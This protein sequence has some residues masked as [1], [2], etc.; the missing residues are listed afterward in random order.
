VKNRT[1]AIIGAVTIAGIA[2]GIVL[3]T[4][5]LKM[6][7]PHAPHVVDVTAEN[8][9]A[10]AVEMERTVS[11]PIE[12]ALS[13]PFMGRVSSVSSQGRTLVRVTLDD[14]AD[15]MAARMEI[16]KR[17]GDVQLPPS[18]FTNIGADSDDALHFAMD[19]APGTDLV[20]LRTAADWIVERALKQLPGVS[21]V[22]TCGGFVKR[23]H[24]DL[25]LF[26]MR[27]YGLSFGDVTSALARPPS[28]ALFAG[29]AGIDEIAKTVI[30]ERHEAPVQVKDVAT[31]AMGHAPRDCVA[32]SGE[33]DEIVLVKVLLRNADVSMLGP[34]IAAR[35]RDL[36][37]ETHARFHPLDFAA[38]RPG[39]FK[40]RAGALVV[41][42]PGEPLA[43]VESL[44][45]TVKRVDGV[46]AF[47]VHRSITSSDGRD[48]V[49]MLL[50]TDAD[51]R[52]VVDI[53]R[54]VATALAR[55]G[56]RSDVTSPSRALPEEL[57]VARVRVLG[58][59]LELVGKAALNVADALGK[60]EGVVGVSRVGAPTPALR[61]D[62]DARV[63][64]R[65]GI[66]PDEV[67][68][69]TQ[70]AL[71]GR[72]VA[73]VVEAEKRFD[74]VLRAKS[75]AAGSNG[76]P[77]EMDALRRVVVTTPDGAAV[78]LG[79]LAT[80]RDELTP[81]LVMRVGGTRYAEVRFSIARMNVLADAK[82]K[83]ASTVALPEGY[84]LSFDQEE[85]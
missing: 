72:E 76:P 6:Q 79:Q 24:V 78:P 84:A 63:V 80:I 18:V 28:A 70:V 45:S 16:T 69:A 73:S 31:V 29:F 56:V 2:A 66:R 34:R 82:K 12:H 27:G 46:R 35:L 15:R 21:D 1:R 23:F 33:K 65:Y 48:A 30:A 83:L 49:E 41:R 25:D 85:W 36:E 57:R 9:G 11:V 10:N 77:A 44:T 22:E 43:P 54:D 60:M 50:E 8:P 17:L 38:D 47:W 37:G 7:R 81:P 3:A 68:L 67:A 71:G 40:A 58:D 26:R 5:W 42:T 64:A 55:R 62:I 4:R 13:A 74:V 32:T 14:A 39:T 51:T 59:D 53:A 61:L 75:D 20:S 52:D 19:P